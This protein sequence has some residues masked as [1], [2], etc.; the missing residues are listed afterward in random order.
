M[1]KITVLFLIMM[2]SVFSYKQVFATT[3]K[4]NPPKASAVITG[5]V[6]DVNTGESLAGVTVTLEGTEMKTYTDLDGNFEFKEMMPG[7]Y[8]L[9]FSFISY[10]KKQVKNVVVAGSE[11]ESIEV[12]L[13]EEN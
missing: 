3:E 5:V 4:G 12:K 8:D 1:K 6:Q 7:T 11:T 2:I 9:V 10:D 13:S